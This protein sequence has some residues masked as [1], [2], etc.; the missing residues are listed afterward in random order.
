MRFLRIPVCSLSLLAVFV[1]A[2]FTTAAH[3]AAPDRISGPIDSSQMVVLAKNTQRRAEPGNDQG[4]VDPGFKLNS[5]TLLTLPSPSQQKALTLLVAEQQDPSSANYHKWLTPEQYAD[6]FGLSQKDV[7]K[8]SEWLQ[9]QDLTV[10]SVARGRNWIVFSGTASQI[11]SAFRTEI[12]QYNVK[13]ETHFANAMPPSIP[14]ALSG[15]AS[16]IRG[17]DDFHPKPSNVR[18]GAPRK[19]NPDFYDNSFQIPDFVAPGDITTIYDL[20]PLYT[21]GFDGTGQKLAI[22]GETDIYLA[23]LNDFRNGFGLT[24]L[25]GCTVNSS[26]VITACN[27]ANFRYVLDGADPGVATPASSILSEADLDLEWSAATA[28][29]AQIIYVNSTDVFTSYYYAIDQALAPVISMS[30]GVCEFG[31]NFIETS[32]GQ[33][34]ADEVELTKSN[35]EG[36]TFINSSGDS[37]AAG[38]DDSTNTATSNLATMGLAAGYPASSPEV[39]GVG[40]TAVAYPAG[41]T[42][43]Y[44]TAPTSN[45]TNGGTAI[46]YMPE[47]SWNDD[48]ELSA[49]YGGTQQSNQESYAIV[50]S[51]GGPSNC[52]EQTSNNLSCVAGFAQPAWQ[53]VTISGQ[54]SARFTP[55]VSLLASPNFPGYIYCTPVEELSTTSPYDT[56]TTSSCATSI[57]DAVNGV[58]TGNTAVVDPSLVG[59]TS[60]SAPVFAGIV[61]VLNQYLNGP[62]SPGLGNIN[63]TLYSLAKTVSSGAFHQVTTG[64][65][66]V[67]CQVGTPT[68]MPVS[69]QCPSAG[70]F[71]YQAS[72][73]DVVTGYN[74][75]TGLGSVDA[76]ALAVAWEA[77][78][79]PDFQLSAG[80]LSPSSVAAGQT[81]TST[82][83]IAPVSGSAAMVVNFNSGSCTGL[84]TGATCSFNPASVTFDGV[85]NATTT[86]TISTTANMAASGPTTITITPTNSAKT[87]A[88]VALTVAATTET[89]AITTPSSSVSVTA[90]ATAT[91]PITV[92]S[93]TGFTTSS[94]GN[95]T[96][97]LPLTYTCT[98]LP[99][100]AACTFSP[101]STS[102]STSVTM[103]ITT[104][105]PSARLERPSDRGTRIFYAALLPGLFGIV[106]VAGSRKGSAR[107]LRML[108]LI[109]MLGFSTLWLGSCGG[110]STSS[111]SNPG[112]PAGSSTV[113]VNATTGGGNAIQ[114]SFQFTL[115][116]SH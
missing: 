41:F 43:T 21:A 112:T 71:G 109:M 81:T 18:K 46:S 3:A 116:V 115:V 85:T 94:G 4:R 58:F 80:A 19:T 111:N 98:G 114:N 2:V 78:I 91:V 68:D 76:N 31:D 51:G 61:T 13:G 27:T 28:P 56:E 83:T 12:H 60:A 44:W 108:S 15:I 99:L 77:T 82:L 74:L 63:P 36:I 16:G 47:T 103:T 45:P 87:T 38:C 110:N 33:P 1:A 67:Y 20:A 39:T 66:T 25:S 50:A 22:V 40:G 57:T 53:T 23:D 48:V 30:F 54:A 107:G 7:R 34:A 113:T 24:P 105:A 79:A 92:T 75:V 93:T 49:A 5:V 104:T 8:I 86:L 11:E 89:V 42:S 97:N 35:S 90:G 72:N 73:S 100:E 84:P 106:F 17:L 88:T 59:G 101:S 37:G 64:S 6:R 70:I 96:T 65:N 9:A 26:G 10:V 55:D 32:T 102:S 14:S 52:A 29:G 69:Y 95:T 62:S